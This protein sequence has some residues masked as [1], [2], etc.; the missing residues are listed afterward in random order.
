MTLKEA[1]TIDVRGTRLPQGAKGLILVD[2]KP[3]G[4]LDAAGAVRYQAGFG[5]AN[6]PAGTHTVTIE[7][8]TSPGHTVL[9][10]DAYHLM[11]PGTR[12]K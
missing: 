6:V 8:Q 7:A 2:G 4:G 1:G 5:Y 10:L 3:A 11:D 12:L 9:A